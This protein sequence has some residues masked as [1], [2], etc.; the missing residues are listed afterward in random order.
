MKLFL[1]YHNG[2]GE[3]ILK[4]AHSLNFKFRFTSSHSVRSIVT[5]DKIKAPFDRDLASYI[6]YG[7]VATPPT[8]EK[9]ATHYLTE[10]NDICRTSEDTKRPYAD[11]RSHKNLR[12]QSPK[13]EGAHSGINRRRSFRRRSKPPRS[14]SIALNARMTSNHQLFAAR[15]IFTCAP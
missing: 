3:G 4:L 2:M 10:S 15:A 7:A 1:P 8:W 6:I 5:N 9:Q 11:S 13:D 14:S 12:G